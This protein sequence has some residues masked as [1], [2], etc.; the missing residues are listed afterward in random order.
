MAIFAKSVLLISLVCTTSAL[1]AING[2]EKHEVDLLSVDEVS[3]LQEAQSSTDAERI[4]D[5]RNSFYEFPAFTRFP[6]LKNY[7]TGEITKNC[8]RFKKRFFSQFFIRI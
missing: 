6:N 5:K 7:R 2:G 3:L 1:P 8:P 4:R